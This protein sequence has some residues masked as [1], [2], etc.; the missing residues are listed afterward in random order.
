MKNAKLKTDGF[1]LIELLVV[2]AIISLLSSIVLASLG[3]ARNK[4]KDASAMESMSSMRAQAELGI[5]SSGLYLANLCNN[6]VPGGL[7]DLIT[8]VETQTGLDTISCGSN[9]GDVMEQPNGWGV[10]VDLLSGGGIYC[11][12]STGYGGIKVGAAN[13]A[14]EINPS[15][16]DGIFALGPS[17]RD[18]I[19]NGQ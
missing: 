15:N 3:T 14:A 1:T 16:D 13:A 4:A 7:F 11:V 8:A 18:F 9:A 5:N 19:C 12:D 17:D 10:A 6:N 2:I